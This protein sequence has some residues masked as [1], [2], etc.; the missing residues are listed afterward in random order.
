[1]T[2]CELILILSFFYIH[3]PSTQL[4]LPQLNNV[5]LKG[6]DSDYIIKRWIIMIQI[7]AKLS[8]RQGYSLI[9]DY[10]ISSYDNCIV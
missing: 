5:I 3:D 1:M 8:T 7:N 2:K 4:T 10:L 9:I 6:L